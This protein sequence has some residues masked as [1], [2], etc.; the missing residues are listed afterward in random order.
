MLNLTNTERVLG[1]YEF[2]TGQDYT[3]CCSSID[4]CMLQS[5]SWKDFH[6]VVTELH[7]EVILLNI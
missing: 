5:L 4:L 6:E 1:I 3:V 7:I 2:I